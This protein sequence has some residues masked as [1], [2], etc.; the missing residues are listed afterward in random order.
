[1]ANG[2]FEKGN[3]SNLISFGL[4]G[5][6]LFARMER[7]CKGRGYG[8]VEGVGVYLDFDSLLMII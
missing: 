5:V 3:V 1:M 4:L 6:G 7:C 2:Y 8:E